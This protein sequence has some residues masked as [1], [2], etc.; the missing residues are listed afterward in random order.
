MNDNYDKNVKNKKNMKNISEN[1]NFIHVFENFFISLEKN[2]NHFLEELRENYCSLVVSKS[3]NGN[4]IIFAYN[5]NDIGSSVYNSL[6]VI[7]LELQKIYPDL[8]C[9][10]LYFTEL[11]SHYSHE[12]DFYYIDKESNDFS[13]CVSTHSDSKFITVSNYNLDNII[14]LKSLISFK[15]K[16]NRNEFINHYFEEKY[17]QKYLV[18]GIFEKDLVINQLLYKMHE[19]FSLEIDNYM[20]FL[21]SFIEKNKIKIDNIENKQEYKLFVIFL[22]NKFLEYDEINYEFFFDKPFFI[23]EY[24]PYIT[25][26]SLNNYNKKELSQLKIKSK[27]N[28]F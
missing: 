25:M 14:Y 9:D 5:K 19:S 27:I 22:N 23:E 13:Y 26:E 17:I 2:K 16:R 8:N 7:F 18:N 21:F 24:L 3:I 11:E 4:Y 1:M 28:N 10:N 6:D 15:Y 20:I 12:V